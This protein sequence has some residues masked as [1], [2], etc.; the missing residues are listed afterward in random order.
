MCSSTKQMDQSG[1]QKLALSKRPAL[2]VVR[3]KTDIAVDPVFLA[4]MS[5]I[6]DLPFRR[7]V[8]GLGAGLVV[9]EMIACEDLVNEKEEVMLRARR[10]AAEEPMAVQLAGREPHWMTEAAKIA[11]GSGARIIDINMGCPAKKVVGGLSGSA[12]MRDLDH[13]LTLIDATLEAVSVPVTLKMRTGWDMDCRNA[14]ELAA[15]AEAAGVALITVHG[16]TRNQFYTGHADWG[17]VREV[18]NAVDVPVI[19]NGDIC[20]IED[21]QNA[22]S[23]SGA[24][25]VMVGRGAQGAPWR[26]GQIRAS[27]EGSVV[28]GDPGTDQR[29]EIILAHYEAILEHYGEALGVRCARKHLAWYV[30][31]YERC[32]GISLRAAKSDMC[33]MSDP[34]DVRNTLTSI[35]NDDATEVAMQGQVA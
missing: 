15:R 2:H 18:K 30:E 32:N 21:A 29:L 4:P 17:F 9:S 31:D 23:Q 14:P 27:L 16:R 33:R 10:E 26:L 28:P 7:T 34:S 6:T 35:F 3:G 25:G 12:L 19:V 20:T 24:D 22:L 5:G 1:P 11:E 13:A 8:R